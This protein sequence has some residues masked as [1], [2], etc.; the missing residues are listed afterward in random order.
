MTSPDEGPEWADEAHLDEVFST[1]V[2]GPPD[3]ASAAE[4]EMAGDNPRLEI[5]EEDI[6]DEDMEA[7][8]AAALAEAEQLSAD[9]QDIEAQ[10]IETAPAAAGRPETSEP[11]SPSWLNVTEPEPPAAGTMA[12]DPIF[13]PEPKPEPIFDP[14][15]EREPIFDP[16][17]VF[18][19][20]PQPEPVFEPAPP[21][22]PEASRVAR[23]WS[24]SDDDI[25]PG[26]KGKGR[27]R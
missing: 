22:P 6:S 20:E 21:P 10:D 19:P 27:R 1:W 13:D 8:L 12:P 11:A 3:S 7:A 17:P 23:P 9:A 26:R 4:K 14:E 25:L 15:P 5:P 16:E 24:R 18:D 2:P